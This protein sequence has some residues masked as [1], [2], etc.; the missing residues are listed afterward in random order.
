MSH[1]P[2][3]NTN[4]VEVSSASS[5]LL[6]DLRF[7]LSQRG[8]C[9]YIRFCQLELLDVIFLSQ[10][11]PRSEKNEKNS[12]KMEKMTFFSTSIFFLKII[13]FVQLMPITQWIMVWAEGISMKWADLKKNRCWYNSEFWVGY[14]L[15]CIFELTCLV[16]KLHGSARPEI[17]FYLQFSV[18]AL[19]WYVS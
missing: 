11:V 13:K 18:W 1:Y 4:F 12:K 8:L 7:R 17:V 9:W 3:L 19:P 10:R 6:T 5:V 15:I 14:N 16:K 2:S